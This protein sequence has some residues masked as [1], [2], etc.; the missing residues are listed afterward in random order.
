MRASRRTGFTLIELL[1]VI[2]IIAIL[3]ALLVPAVQKVREAAAR[4]TCANNLKQIVLATH[5]Y[6]DKEYHFPSGNLGPPMQGSNFPAGWNDTSV[7]ATLPFGYFSWSAQ[8][9]PYVE[10]NDLYNALDFSKP[11]YVESLIENGSQRGPAGNAVNK[12]VAMNTPAVFVCPVAH[13]VGLPN[14]QKDYGI[15][16]GQNNTCCPERHV[17]AS[18][19]N[20]IAWCNSKLK[21]KEIIDGTS[22]TLA[23]AELAAYSIHSWLDKEKGSNP[24]IFVHHASEGYVTS[25]EGGNPEPP[26]WDFTNTRSARSAHRG[27]IQAVMADGHLVWISESINFAVYTAFFSR[28]GNEPP[29][30]PE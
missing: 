27:G 21:M 28:N 2:A 3:I 26:N 29:G 16:G 4:T 14:T 1:V 20:G 30:V 17:S 12:P 13:Q 23:Y 19:N 11:A 24:F 10:Q 22:N 15:N 18:Q 6:Y 7:G 25:G 8:I 5:N 9:L